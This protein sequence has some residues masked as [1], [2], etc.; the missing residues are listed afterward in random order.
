MKKLLIVLIALMIFS[1]PQPSY[2]IGDVERGVVIGVLG[3]LGL[4]H[5]SNQHS[6]YHY[7]RVEV[8]HYNYH[9]RDRYRTYRYE[10][11][12]VYME[13]V[14]VTQ[15]DRYGQPDGYKKYCR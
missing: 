11:R 1:V 15:H 13:C 3:V 4:Q 7:G 8:R 10:P 9:H 2:A 6:H 14:W 12:E 5:I